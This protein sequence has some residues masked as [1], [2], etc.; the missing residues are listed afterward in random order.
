[1]QEG[2][3]VDEEQCIDEPEGQTDDEA[4]DVLKQDMQDVSE[5][6]HDDADNAAAE[7]ASESG[8][9]PDHE[10]LPPQEDV[11]ME[12]ASECEPPAAQAAASSS[13]DGDDAMRK[14]SC[15]DCSEFSFK[16]NLMH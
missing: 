10:P 16:G 14:D 11:M 12:A 8:K 2:E 9:P 4:L 3:E 5:V 15:F 1:M 7:V 6:S 13:G